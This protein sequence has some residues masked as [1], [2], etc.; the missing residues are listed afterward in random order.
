MQAFNN[1]SADILCYEDMHSFKRHTCCTLE[2]VPFRLPQ[3]HPTSHLEKVEDCFSFLH[4]RGLPGLVKHR[5]LTL[6]SQANVLVNPSVCSSR[7]ATQASPLACYNHTQATSNAKH[8]LHKPG[9]GLPPMSSKSINTFSLTSARSA[10]AGPCSTLMRD[11]T[12]P[13][14]TLLGEFFQKVANTDMRCC[15]DNLSPPA[16]RVT[17]MS[18]STSANASDPQTSPLPYPFMSMEAP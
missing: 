11:R 1:S 5:Q 6:H 15:R 2:S 16:A 18:P 14:R 12:A 3:S 10:A 17:M 7:Q 8:T 9:G 4:L 13:A